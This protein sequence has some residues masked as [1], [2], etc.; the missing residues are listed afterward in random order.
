MHDDF[1]SKALVS[2]VQAVMHNYS[3]WLY[4]E[5]ILKVNYVLEILLSQLLQ[6]GSLIVSVVIVSFRV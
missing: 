4:I 5:N 6:D 1:F 3:I 2:E